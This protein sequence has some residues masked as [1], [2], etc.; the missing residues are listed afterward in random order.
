MSI[1]SLENSRASAAPT[2]GSAKSSA[3]R[4]RKVTST[5]VVAKK[6]VRCLEVREKCRRED[7]TEG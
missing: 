6:P 4:R 7:A 3:L 2:K 5:T 1:L